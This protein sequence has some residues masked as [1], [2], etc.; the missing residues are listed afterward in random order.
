MDEDKIDNLK[1]S[2]VTE[3]LYSGVIR[4]CLKIFDNYF[5]DKTTSDKKSASILTAL[6]A[7]NAHV[8]DYV[9]S[10]SELQNSFEKTLD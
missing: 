1:D 10:E 6:A 3:V 9:L 4:K 2:D 8:C 5:Y 7:I